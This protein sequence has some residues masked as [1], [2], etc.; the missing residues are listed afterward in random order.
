MAIN[1]KEMSKEQDLL[2]PGHRLCAGCA[3]TIV[4][5]QVLHAVGRPVVVAPPPGNL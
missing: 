2:A 3:E 1:L 5:R 4:V